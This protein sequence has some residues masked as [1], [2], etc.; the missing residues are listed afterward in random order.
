MFTSPLFLDEPGE[1]SWHNEWFDF[2]FMGS[3]KFTVWNADFLTAR[4]AFW[5]KVSELAYHKAYELVSSEE[6]GK[7]LDNNGYIENLEREIITEDPPAIY[8]FFKQDNSYVYGTGLHIVLDV[9]EI[10]RETIEE[11][12]HKFFALGQKSWRSENPV[13]RESLPYSTEH[14]TIKN[15]E[16]FN[17]ALPVRG[18]YAKR[19]E[20]GGL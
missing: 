15:E 4:M 10:N 17:F 5:D 9:E 19:W 16:R 14:D 20:K 18:K 7:N 1:P 8:E 12:I 11:A 2:M 13:P 3:D 6:I